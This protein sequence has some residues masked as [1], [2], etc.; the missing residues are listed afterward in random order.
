[1]PD[2]TWTPFIQAIMNNGFAIAV[3]A[4]LLAR[5]ERTLQEVRDTVKRTNA[6]LA[7][8]IGQEGR[9]LP[10]QAMNLIEDVN[11]ETA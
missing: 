9:P 3:A 7:A 10:Q 1:M 6:I 5:M 8:H 11:E 4:Y 2:Q